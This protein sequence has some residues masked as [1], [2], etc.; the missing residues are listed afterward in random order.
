MADQSRGDRLRESLAKTNRKAAGLVLNVRR[1][2]DV[3][4]LDHDRGDSVDS[5]FGFCAACGYFGRSRHEKSLDRSGRAI[6]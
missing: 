1:L 3:L 4:G 6:P 2:D 5:Y